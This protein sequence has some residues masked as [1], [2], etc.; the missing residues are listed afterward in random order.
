MWAED[1]HCIRPTEPKNTIAFAVASILAAATASAQDKDQSSASPLEE[2]IVTSSG[3]A[4]SIAEV[5]YNLSVVSADDLT[6]AG[7]TNI[8]ELSRQ[9]PGLTYLDMGVRSNSVNNGLIIR[10]LNGASA[11]ANANSPAAG[12]MTVSTYV[13]STPL[14]TNLK[15]TDVARVEVLRGPQGTLY[16]AGSVGGTVRFIF[17]EPDFDEFSADVDTK[18]SQTTDSDSAGYSVDAIVNLP[19]SE[20]FALRISAGYADIAGTIDAPN[21]TVYDSSGN[22]VLANPGDPFGGGRVTTSKKDVDSASIRYGRAALLWQ[23]TDTFSSLLTIQHQEDDADDFTAQSIHSDEPMHTRFRTSPANTTVDLYALELTMDLGFAT[24]TSSSAFSDYKL[25]SESDYTNYA[26]NFQAYYAGFPRITD[27][28]AID[29]HTKRYT[30]EFRLVSKT[31]GKWD[32]VAGAYYSKEDTTAAIRTVIPGW[33]QFA[34]TPG[35][36]DAVAAIGPGASYADYVRLSYPDARFDND[37]T[38]LLD[39]TVKNPHTALYGELTYHFT[40]QWQVTGGL[41]AFWL[42]NDRSAIQGYPGEGAAGDFAAY[43]ESSSNDHI[44][45]FNTSYQLTADQ[46]VYFTYSEGFRQGGSNALPLVGFFAADPALIPYESDFSKNFEVGSKGRLGNRVQYSSALYYINWDSIQVQIPA[47]VSG[48]PT[49][50]NGGDAV[51]RGVE[52]EATAALTPRLTTTLGYTFT[53]AHLTESF[54]VRSGYNG[55][56]G[57]RMPGVPRHSVIASLNYAQ[58][59]T[60]GG[61]STLLYRIDGAYRSSTNTSL[62]RASRNYVELPGFD[63]WNASVAWQSDKMRVRLFIDN[64]TDEEGVTAADI[65]NDTA[66]LTRPGSV[67]FIQRPR[68]FGVGLGYSF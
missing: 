60:W 27:Y 52:L 68:T 23:P 43:T 1:S 65:Q 50:V 48:I 10:G 17:N 7:V 35:H 63:T 32:W 66:T 3:R 20:Q 51:S 2:V 14:F 36:P 41:R 24:L 21:L 59:V 57:D 8:A 15:I 54:V 16:G 42:E 30:Q 12:E 18:L 39:K 49:L 64:L 38:W 40:D 26:L 29:Y 37:N 31:G 19:L 25:D 56:D 33:A 45:K 47:P 4:Q 6:S 53:D 55:D 11:G 5:P 34:T 28:T 13:N 46:Q 44:F 61:S 58:P 67:Y 22:P 62:N 9:V